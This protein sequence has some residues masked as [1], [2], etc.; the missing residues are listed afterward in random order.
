[1]SRPIPCGKRSVQLRRGDAQVDQDS[2][3]VRHTESRLD[4]EQAALVVLDQLSLGGG[5]L[6]SCPIAVD[7]DHLAR[8]VT[9]EEGAGVAA[10]AKACIKEE[11]LLLAVVE[12]GVGWSG[13]R[14]SA[15]LKQ[16]PGLRAL[17]PCA[18]V[19]GLKVEG[20]HPHRKVN[21]VMLAVGEEPLE[22]SLRDSQN[23]SEA[24]LLKSVE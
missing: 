16:R 12:V 19:E 9:L 2:I 15:G 11:A 21:Q 8:G 3:H 4:R 10:A 23:L 13:G 24:E 6:E 14:V 7:G 1:M 22:K 5:A 18:L 20:C 17:S